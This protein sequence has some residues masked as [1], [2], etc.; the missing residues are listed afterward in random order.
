MFIY[1]PDKGKNIS[2]VIH[3]DG[4]KSTQKFTNDDNHWEWKTIEEAKKEL[5]D[6]GFFENGEK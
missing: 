3:L 1:Y 5:R 6:S 4:R 2:R